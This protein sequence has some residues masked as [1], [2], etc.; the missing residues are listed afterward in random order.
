MK[1]VRSSLVALAVFGI[2]AA[3]APALGAQRSPIRGGLLADPAPTWEK[4][5]GGKGRFDVLR[6]FDGAAVLDDETGL[7][8]ERTPA[9]AGPLLWAAAQGYCNRLHTG[10]RLGWRLPTLQELASLVDPSAAVA[11]LLPVD[12]PFQNVQSFFPYWS[13]TTSAGDASSAWAVDF[14]TGD[15]PV[16]GKR[17]GLLVWCVRGGQGVDPQ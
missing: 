12:H 10:S 3:V 14:N 2:C 7:V 16:V 17:N 5:I 6:Q 8:W 13:A 9:G 15:V 1:G 11:P 4:Q